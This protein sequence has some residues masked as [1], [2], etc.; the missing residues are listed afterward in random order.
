MRLQP[1]QAK[2]LNSNPPSIQTFQDIKETES[3]MLAQVWALPASRIV[4]RKLHP[5][6]LSRPWHNHAEY[7]HESLVARLPLSAA[8][9]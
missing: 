7:L 8:F 4:N 2:L 9:P 6:L 5:V 1:F 3:W